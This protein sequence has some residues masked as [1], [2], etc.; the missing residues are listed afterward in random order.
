M[1]KSVE[2]GVP[3]SSGAG[4]IDNK[5]PAKGLEVVNPNPERWSDV[6]YAKVGP[7]QHTDATGKDTYTGIPG[8]GIVP[9]Y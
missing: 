8:D 3:L 7:N 6:D 5:T 9:G 4:G 1:S 2:G